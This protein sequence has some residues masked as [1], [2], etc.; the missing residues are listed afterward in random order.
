MG[1]W[2]LE[3]RV[4]AGHSLAGVALAGGVFRGSQY[5]QCRLEKPG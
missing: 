4:K 2:L 1:R 5:E 3:S